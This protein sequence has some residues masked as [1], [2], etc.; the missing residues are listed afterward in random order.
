MG[1]KK[2]KRKTVHSDQ[3]GTRN[4]RGLRENNLPLICWSLTQAPSG[5]RERHLGDQLQGVPW[6]G[7]H[8]FPGPLDFSLKLSDITFTLGN[9][10][11][12]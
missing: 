9:L 6:P 4:V 10:L 1:E 11:T 8:P 2:R 12:E 3:G 5:G 7:T